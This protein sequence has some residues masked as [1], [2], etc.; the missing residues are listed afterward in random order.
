MP[1]NARFEYHPPLIRAYTRSITADRAHHGMATQSMMLRLHATPL[2]ETND[3]APE[4][5]LP[6][7]CQVQQT[8]RHEEATEPAPRPRLPLSCPYGPFRRMCNCS[9]P[10]RRQGYLPKVPLYTK[11]RHT[12]PHLSMQKTTR[13]TQGQPSSEARAA[14]WKIWQVLPQ[15]C[16]STTKLYLGRAS[17]A[18]PW[19]RKFREILKGAT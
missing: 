4:G 13:A 12:R 10:C 16:A 8:Q 9:C 6:R 2:K 11:T 17:V 19:K 3:P 14:N 18:V 15:A 5:P 7:S 1:T